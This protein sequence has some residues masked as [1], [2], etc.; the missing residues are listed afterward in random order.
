[1]TKKIL[2]IS[3]AHPELSKGGAEVASWN[4]F[5]SLKEAGHECLYLARSENLSHGG[6]TFSV[7]QQDQIMLHTSI[8]DWFCLSSSNTKHLFDDLGEL[9]KEFSPDIMHVH[10]YAHIGIEIFTALKRAAPQ[11][12]LIFTLHEYMAICMHNGQM[13]KNNSLKLCFKE[14]PADCNRCFP[15]R[16]PADF[17]LRKQYILDQ[18][19]SVDEFIS[20]SQFLADRYIDWG[21]PKNKMHV[22]EN[23]LPSFEKLLPR[24]L[25]TEKKRGRLAFFGQLNLYKGIDILLQALALLPEDI[26]AHIHLDIHGANLELQSQAFQDKVTLL[27]EDVQELVTMRGAYESEQLPIL[28][29]ETDWVI[30]P[31]IW[32]ENAPVVIQE[33]I[34]LGRPLI[35]SNIGGMKEK[36]EGIAGLTFQV[37]SPASLAN[38]IL[39][40]IEP[41]TFDKNY[42]SLHTK[43]DMYDAHLA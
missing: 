10:H 32:W 30:I 3:H 14:S 22:I 6:S 15:E 12:K 40:A 7:R 17:F 29:Q 33:A 11:A 18:F 9:V 19:A 2:I 41:L 26:K 31:S 16:S 13:V 24:P 23:I 21:I 39:E 43:V 25:G 28:M 36:I 34:A 4:L 5:Q 8:T 35:G 20:P 38:A 27:L 42:H 37:K 1:M